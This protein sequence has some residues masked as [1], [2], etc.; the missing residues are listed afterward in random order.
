MIVS[1]GTPDIFVLSVYNLRLFIFCASYQAG[2]FFCT[3]KSA[4][5]FAMINTQSVTYCCVLSNWLVILFFSLFLR[6]FHSGHVV[7]W[8]SWEISV[9]PEVGEDSILPP[10][11]RGRD[12]HY[13]SAVFGPQAHPQTKRP[14]TFEIKKLD[15]TTAHF[16]WRIP[17]NKLNK[18][19][20]VRL[21]SVTLHC[22]CFS[23]LLQWGPP[24]WPME[25]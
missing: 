24:R 10:G 13:W 12:P 6:L 2:Y 3:S 18:E 8:Y 21:H 23:E 1:G 11:E 16:S 4:L 22:R 17:L 15:A 25:D 7:C 5:F 14:T 19:A 20:G 9:Q